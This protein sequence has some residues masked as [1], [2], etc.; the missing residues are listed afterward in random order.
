MF[1]PPRSL[2]VKEKVFLTRS[3]SFKNA[4]ERD[5]LAAALKAFHSMALNKLRQLDARLRR[6]S[7]EVKQAARRRVLQGTRMRDSLA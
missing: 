3:H 2:T 5:A 6:H 4:H 7:P 1:V